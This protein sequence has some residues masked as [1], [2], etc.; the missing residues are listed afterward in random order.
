MKLI[1]TAS[2]QNTSILTCKWIE[3]PSYSLHLFH[4][5]RHETRYFFCMFVATCLTKLYP[6]AV[7]QMIEAQNFFMKKTISKSCLFLSSAKN[8][9]LFEV[10]ILITIIFSY[11]ITSPIFQS[12]AWSLYIIKMIVQSLPASPSAHYSYVVFTWPTV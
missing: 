6:N 8:I 10:F 5:M 4:C 2:L 12:A 1:S 7:P 9:H 11:T 3:W